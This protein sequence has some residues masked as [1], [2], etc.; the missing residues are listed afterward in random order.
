[1]EFD[2]KEVMT[3]ENLKR[4]ADKFNF[5]NEEDMFAAVGYNGITAA[6]IANRLTEKLR[7]RK[8]WMKHSSLKI[9]PS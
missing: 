9:F 5:A 2:I 6:Q 7:K 4:V 3:S 8:I 1:M